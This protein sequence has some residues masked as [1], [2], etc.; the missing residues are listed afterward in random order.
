MNAN[1]SK[2]NY[3]KVNYITTKIHDELKCEYKARDKKVKRRCA[4]DT[5]NG[6]TRR[7]V[8]R[9]KLRVKETTSHCTGS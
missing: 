1:R 2:S 6:M 7:L 9:K 3:L 4:K 5:S 8:K